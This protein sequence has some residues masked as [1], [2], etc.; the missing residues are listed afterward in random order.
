[1]FRI[2]SFELDALYTYLGA[3]S[4]TDGISD[5]RPTGNSFRDNDVS[6]VATAMQLKTTDDMVIT[7]EDHAAAVIHVETFGLYI[8]ILGDGTLLSSLRF[9]FLSP[10]NRTFL[11]DV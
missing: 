8:I 5:G 2:G 10:N 3:D 6:N 4:P 11:L 7:G 1:M 9:L